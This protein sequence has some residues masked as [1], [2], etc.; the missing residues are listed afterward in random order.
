MPRRYPVT[1]VHP[2]LLFAPHGLNNPSRYTDPSGHI[3]VD[4]YGTTYCGAS[5]SHL[6][7]DF[8]PSKPKDEG[9]DPHIPT[10]GDGLI[11]PPEPPVQPPIL[12]ST[13]I[14]LTSS[15]ELH[16]SDILFA[17][18]YTYAGSY[19]LN[20]AN[21]Q[22][23]YVYLSYKPDYSS[24]RPNWSA[25]FGIKEIAEA[26]FDFGASQVIERGLKNFGNE[27]LI[28]L[29]KRASWISTA[30]DFVTTTNDFVVFDSHI[31]SEY[32]YLSPNYSPPPMP[33]VQDFVYPL[34]PFYL[35]P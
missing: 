2:A 18:K 35:N 9:N 11:G 12:T 25:I 28:A 26:G 34:N 14:D 1:G 32:I 7:P 30:Y 33:N 10:Y 20:R 16:P 3:P 22:R 27:S 17:G 31:E 6:L 24:A 5:N 23:Y 19:I 4:C 21:G 15:H 13:V 29:A 8:K